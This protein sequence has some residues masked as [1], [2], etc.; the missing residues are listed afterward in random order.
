M[1]KSPT[2]FRCKIC[3]V[4]VVSRTNLKAILGRTHGRHCPR[5]YK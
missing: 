5:R 3:K 4:P 1:G 2:G